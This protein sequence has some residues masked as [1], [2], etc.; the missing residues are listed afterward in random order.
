MTDAIVTSRLTKLFGTQCA[1]NGTNCFAD[2][3]DPSTANYIQKTAQANLGLQ[4]FDAA[5]LAPRE[6]VDQR[7]VDHLAEALERRAVQLGG[8]TLVRVDGNVKVKLSFR[9]DA[10]RREHA[11]TK[12]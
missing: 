6:R 11:G 2:V 1:V 8:T 5:A 12:R 10:G 3:A 4:V 9:N 7:N